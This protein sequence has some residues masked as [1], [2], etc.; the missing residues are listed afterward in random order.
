MSYFISLNIRQ[1]KTPKVPYN[2]AYRYI[3]GAES[4]KFHLFSVV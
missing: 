1:K 4:V 2:L 3:Y